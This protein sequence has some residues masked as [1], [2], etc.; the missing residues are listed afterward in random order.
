MRHDIGSPE[1]R[2]LARLLPPDVT[3]ERVVR[4]GDG[5][6][7]VATVWHAIAWSR[8]GRIDRASDLLDRAVPRGG[9]ERGWVAA[10]RA[11]PL[12]E[13]G[14]HDSARALEAPALDDARDP[15]VVALLMTG[16]AADAVGAG[17]ASEAT[18]QLQRAVESLRTL[19]ADAPATAR[20][21]L[22]AS[23]VAAEVALLT[24]RGAT[25][26]SVEVAHATGIDLPSL[27][28]LPSPVDGDEV[29]TIVW[30]ADHDAGSD[31]H[32]AKAL[33]FA[34][35]LARSDAILRRADELAPPMLAWAIALARA[36]LAAGG[37][38]ASDATRA[39]ALRARAREVWGTLVLPDAI[40]ATVAATPVGRLL[41]PCGRASRAAG[42][43]VRQ[44]ATDRVDVHG[45]GSPPRVDT[46]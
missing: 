46:C 41:G 13:L 37:P 18:T 28:S 45:T 26:V 19:P 23:W 7:L 40:H 6:D 31:A 29:G 35:T 24:G 36:D 12:R 9:D 14:L 3:V 4:A 20:A 43:A 39:D 8:L 33:L 1:P 42:T 17:D 2:A 16:L 25:E 27:P 34:G 22:R 21:R 30:H 44:G 5:T 10:E 32:R 15:G 38:T 11:R